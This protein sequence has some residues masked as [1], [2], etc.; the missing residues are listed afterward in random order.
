MRLLV[1]GDYCLSNPPLRVAIVGK[2]CLIFRFLISRLLISRLLI[3]R[4]LR[5]VILRFRIRIVRDD[6]PILIHNHPPNNPIRL[7]RF[8]LN[9][10]FAALQLRQLRKLLN[11]HSLNSLTH[12]IAP[13]IRRRTASSP[14]GIIVIIP[15]PNPSHHLGNVTNKPQIPDIFRSTSFARYSA[16]GLSRRPPRTVLHHT[17]QHPSSNRST[18]LIQNPLRF[19]I[20]LINHI[21]P[22][23]NHPSN[24]VGFNKIPLRC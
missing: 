24:A 2:T 7:H 20:S 8:S 4:L 21:S 15:Q 12:K 5:W 18:I 22:L 16:I 6:R 14:C 23:I 11:R 1:L 10:A 17:L 3:S 19:K 13:I 9:T